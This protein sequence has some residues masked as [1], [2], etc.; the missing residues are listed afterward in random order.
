MCIGTLSSVEIIAP[1]T[2]KTLW[3]HQQTILAAIAS[4]LCFQNGEPRIGQEYLIVLK[5]LR[6]GDQNVDGLLLKAE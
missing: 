6:Y 2:I 4:T 3:T 5:A 1:N